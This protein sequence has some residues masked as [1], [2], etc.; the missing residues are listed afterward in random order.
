MRLPD[1]SEWSLNDA[2]GMGDEEHNRRLRAM[3]EKGRAARA[4]EPAK[5]WGIWNEYKPKTAQKES[6]GEYGG[7]AGDETFRMG[8][9]PPAEMPGGAGLRQ[10]PGSGRGGALHMAGAGN[11]MDGMFESF[12]ESPGLSQKEKERIDKL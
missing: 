8:A 4:P 10:P 11:R 2:L 12:R 3:R 5:L 7:Y 1:L 9:W 6:A